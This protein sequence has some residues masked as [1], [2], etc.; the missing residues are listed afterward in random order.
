[1]QDNKRKTLWDFR[2]SVAPA[3]N[4]VKQAVQQIK[5]LARAFAQASAMRLFFT[6]LSV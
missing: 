3:S 6:M 1:L 5:S 2:N 4:Q